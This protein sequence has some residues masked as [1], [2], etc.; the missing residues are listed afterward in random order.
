ML[1]MLLEICARVVDVGGDV[2]VIVYMLCP[3]VRLLLLLLLRVLLLLLLL[4]L[5]LS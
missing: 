1:L 3:F 2:V 4:S 5:M